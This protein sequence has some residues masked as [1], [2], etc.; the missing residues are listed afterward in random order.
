MNLHSHHY[1]KIF[2]VNLLDNKHYYSHENPD[3]IISRS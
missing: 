1:N 2:D 3:Y